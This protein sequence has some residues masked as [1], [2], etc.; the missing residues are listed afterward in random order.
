MPAVPVLFDIRTFQFS[1][2][3]IELFLSML[4]ILYAR[5]R[6]GYPGFGI[7]SFQ[8]ACFA[9]AQM[10]GALRGIIPDSISILG[11]NLFNTLGVLLIYEALTRYYTGNAL[12]RRWYLLIPIVLAGIEYWY[13]I[14][15]II[16]YR[17]ALVSLTYA[18][19]VILITR[20]I[21]KGGST[22]EVMLTRLQAIIYLLLAGIFAVRGIDYLISPEGRSFFEN[23]PINTIF[24]LYVMIASIGSSF[25]FIILNFERQARELDQSHMQIQ[26]LA[27][28]NDLA[29][30]SAGAGVWEM[31][32]DTR[33][34][35]TDNQIVRMFGLG[36]DDKQDITRAILERIHPD[37]WSL[38]NATIEAIHNEGVHVTQE[39][40]MQMNSG[41]NRYH[42][43][44]ARSFLKENGKG[45]R[46]IGLSTDITPLRQAQIALSTALRK[47]TILSGV[48]R[49]DILNCV[50]AIG[51]TSQL[52]HSEMAD[53]PELQKHITSIESIGDQITRLIQFTREYEELG[54]Q[55]PLW[56]DLAILLSKG[57]I[58]NML[59]T[60]NLLFPPFG[61]RIY[62]DRMIEKVFY[63]L[64]DNSIRHGGTVHTIS[65]T[66]QYDGRDLL[67]IYSDDGVGVPESEKESIFSQGVGKNTGL[68]LFLCREILAI[69][70]LTIKENGTEGVGARFE[71][72]A[73]PGQYQDM[74]K[75][76]GED[77]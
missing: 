56:T 37:D 45:L 44:N 62:G 47:I 43:A 71:I 50:T 46:L 11:S 22:D 49:H 18:I 7:W 58:E 59:K 55:E 4:M 26:K 2:I 54:N 69:T 25:L 73:K 66:Y 12:D 6:G 1:I 20:V 21:L 39:Y 36:E 76:V 3:L 42:L 77:S 65:I 68:G 32:L 33:Q 27:T 17:S 16:A 9:I 61:V 70:G 64:I 15:D 13:V 34:L 8:L 30:T 29:I 24:Y 74:R 31:D 52:L 14:V 53:K 57:A 63:N 35:S 28:R 48:T 38:M 67:I 10:F 19:I 51:L 23:G 40:R 72:R 5:I 60:R 41:E 75:A